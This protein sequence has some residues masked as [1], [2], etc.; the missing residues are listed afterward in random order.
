MLWDTG[1]MGKMMWT[2]LQRRLVERF[3]EIHEGLDNDEE[4]GAGASSWLM[5]ERHHC[6]FSSVSLCLS[7]CVH[8]SV[9]VRER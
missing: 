1:D 8:V 2:D 9:C 5:L 6:K 4:V 3:F 7:A